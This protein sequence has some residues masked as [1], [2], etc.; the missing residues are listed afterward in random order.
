MDLLSDIGISKEQIAKLFDLIENK[1]DINKKSDIINIAN[2]IKSKYNADVEIDYKMVRGM[3]Y[4]TGIIF[5]IKH[6][7]LGLS[8]AGG[9]QYKNV[10]DGKNRLHRGID[11]I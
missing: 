6:N 9:G 4:Y 10:F 1:N 2:L 8:I 7:I 3:N 5:E 11:W